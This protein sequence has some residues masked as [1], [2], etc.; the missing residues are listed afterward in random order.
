MKKE[1]IY[2]WTLIFIILICLP[3]SWVWA[4]GGYF[5]RSIALSTDQ[6]AIIIK[7][8]D[9]ISITLST[10]Y[11]GEGEDFGWIIPTPVPPSIEDVNEA[12]EKGELTFE[13][14]DKKTVPVFTEVTGCFPSGTEVLTAT[15]PRA[16]ETV[17]PGTE[18]Y[19]FDVAMKI[20]MLKRVLERH[21]HSYEGDMISIQVD[22]N[23]IRATGNHPFYV[24]RGDR[25]ASRPLARDIPKEELREGGSGHWVEARDLKKGDL[26]QNRIGD[27][28]S[29]SSLSRRNEKI[30]VYNLSIEGSHNYAVYR[31]GILVHNKG[32]SSRS[33][34]VTVY[35]TATIDNYEVN[36]LGAATTA[37]LLNWLQKNGYEVDPSAREIIDS[38]V[39]MNWAFVAVKH[40]PSEKRYYKNEF[41]P[42][43]TIRYQ[44]DQLIF[45]L[46]ISSVSTTQPAKITL[47]VIAES[48]FTSSNLPTQ[49]LRYRD[50]LSDPVYPESYIESRITKTMERE[51]E[52]ALIVMW[53]GKFAPSNDQKEIIDGL[54]KKPFPRGENIYLTRL[55]SRINPAS[56]TDDIRFRIDPHPEEFQVRILADKGFLS[57]L[58]FATQSGEIDTVRKLLQEGADANEL[59]ADGWTP[60]TIAVRSGHTE[61]AEILLAVGAEVNV[62]DEYG[63]TPLMWAEGGGHDELVQI[64]LQAGADVKEGEYRLQAIVT[65]AEHGRLDVVQMLLHEGAD[66]NARDKYG[67]SALAKAA[68]GGHSEVVKLLLQAGAKGNRRSEDGKTALMFAAGDGDT[69]VVKLLLRAGA[70]VKRK[71]II[72]GRTALMFA[73]MGGH[74]E[75][76]W[77]LLQAGAEVDVMD[78]SNCTALMLAADRGRTA[79]VK[80]L[81]E[82]GADVHAGGNQQATLRNAAKK[83]YTQIVQILLE[84]GTDVNEMDVH[85]NTI[86][87][88][89][90]S[91]GHARVVK[92]LLEGGADVNATH[93]SAD[94]TALMSA[95]YYGHTEIVR[96]L[97]GAGA[98]VNAKNKYGGTALMIAARRGYADIVQLLVTA[99][100]DVNARDKDG[101]TALMLAEE[102]GHTPIVNILRKV[103]VK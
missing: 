95:S 15:G 103:G 28:L 2:G 7:N 90:V 13:F 53:S 96:T 76:V 10:G 81:L 91:E 99:G 21:T 17:D 24:L 60:L 6:R 84:A 82:E 69:E 38:Y 1:K 14:L 20:W 92:I 25:L 54:M 72:E 79:V 8:G 77:I 102:E 93:P 33:P 43:L 98:D 61:I 30:E 31:K 56:M 46:R 58:G 48:T 85:G 3:A 49:T 52:R 97:I 78:R 40:D 36:V 88:D 73:A 70:K 50:R 55:E 57:G 64:L 32:V 75:V 41:L 19:S 9:E 59:N 47:F 29:I 42:P 5:S 11:T 86:L 51:S 89:A 26:L 66:A 100:A 35:G 67:F 62:V 87:W 68:K 74:S 80:T 37:D 27:C 101:R 12:G 23:T 4:D 83:G 94:M 22:H 18:V 45:P 71:S 34:H 44:S 65:A 39:R 63:M 16:I